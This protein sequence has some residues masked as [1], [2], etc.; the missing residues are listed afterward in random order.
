MSARSSMILSVGLPAPWPALVSMRI[1]IGAGPGLRGLQRRRELE[2][3]RRHHAVVV[4]GR[5]HQRR[6]VVRAGLDVV[7]RRVLQTRVE[8]GLVL[9]RLSRSR[10]ATPSRS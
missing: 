1:R 7:E 9:V 4:V 8:V 6:R 2:A 3:V 5:G 10:T